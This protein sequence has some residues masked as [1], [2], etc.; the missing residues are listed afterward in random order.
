M[1]CNGVKCM[2]K[3]AS[4]AER[5]PEPSSVPFQSCAQFCM[6]ILTIRGP[7]RAGNIY[8]IH[9]WC[10][11]YKV[12]VEP[13]LLLPCEYENVNNIVQNQHCR[14]CWQRSMFQVWKVSKNG[15]LLCQQRRSVLLSYLSSVMVSQVP[16][17]HTTVVSHEARIIVM[18]GS[19]WNTINT[20][21]TGDYRMTTVLCWQYYHSRVYHL[22]IR[23]KLC[24]S[25][26]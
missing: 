13:F 8:S 7:Q 1:H 25:C 24:Q 14:R 18:W 17:C 15:K 3:K 6:G 11:R 4:N 16:W 9:Q 26:G 20:E 21:T 22:H 23:W 5:R 19:H 10:C 2:A 12:L